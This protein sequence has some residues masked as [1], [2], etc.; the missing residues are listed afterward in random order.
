MTIPP[1]L[2][3]QMTPG[4]RAFVELLLGRIAE[5]EGEVAELRQQL[6]EARRFQRGANDESAPGQSAP[7]QPP[8]DP[9]GVNSPSVDP[10]IQNAAAS[11]RKTATKRKRGG[12]PGHPKHERNLIPTRD[13]DEVLVHRP[14][15]CRRCGT[16]LSGDDP[17]PLRHQIFELPEIKLHVT[18]HQL[19]RLTCPCCS[20]QT[21]AELPPG[22]TT[23]Q[24][25]PRLVAFTALLMGMF[26]QS[27]RRVAM[28]CEA[29][30][31]HPISPGLVVKH[32][33]QASEALAEAHQEL[34]EQ[35]P[36]QEAV[37]ADETPTKQEN[38]NAWIWTVVAATFTVFRIRATKAACVIREL[39]GNEFEGVATSDRAKTYH[40][41]WRHQWCWA[42]LRRDFE[43]M[44]LRPGPAGS[45]GQQ[46]LECTHKLFHDWHL[47]RDGT[48]NRRGFECRMTRLRSRVETLLA[49]GAACDN[50][51]TA[52]TCAELLTYSQ[53]LW[54]FVYCP[55]VEPTN[56]DAE[57]SL[58]HAVIW[59]HLSF[60]TQ[61][62]HGSRFVERL[63]TV[64]ETCRQQ[65]LNPFQFLIQSIT[66]K[67]NN[68]NAP[69]LLSGA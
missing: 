45:I 21:C 67:R 27:K 2:E 15:A 17:V 60:G 31:N 7:G 14:K 25:G 42:H 53:N 3:A 64:I 43:K 9:G 18:E 5:I 10:V 58:R 49:E 68:Q 59:K 28:F 63:L 19:H 37:C 30:L 41:L 20:K 26:R 13:C 36:D 48:I 24:S 50:R 4:V 46:L 39:L 55:G 12:Q 29:L 6:A 65:K 32:Q 16:K 1:E 8:Q 66:A 34:V 40:W 47:L 38:R 57:R 51:A 52:A 11:L 61:S 23:S 54:L 62:D 22:V 44:L 33:R 69:S 56:N 35:L